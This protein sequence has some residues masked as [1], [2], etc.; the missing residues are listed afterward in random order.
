MNTTTQAHDNTLNTKKLSTKSTKRLNEL[1]PQIASRHF[2]S[3]QN[4]STNNIKNGN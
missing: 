1:K 3:L 2:L 4:I